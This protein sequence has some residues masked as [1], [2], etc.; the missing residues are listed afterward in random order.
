MEDARARP[1]IENDDVQLR[2]FID[3]MFDEELVERR[4]RSTE[5]DS[6]RRFLRQ[7]NKSRS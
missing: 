3:D 6:E 1:F 7:Q 5:H 4:K 2:G